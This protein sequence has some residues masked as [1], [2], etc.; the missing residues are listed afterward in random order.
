LLLRE[1]DQRLGLLHRLAGCFRDYR[2]PNSTEYSVK[3]LVA[4]R[5]Y[6]L[7]L[8]YEDLNDHETLRSDRPLR[9]WWASATSPASGA[10]VPVTRAIHWR[11]RAL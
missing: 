7:A 10:G 4:Q 9:C 6:G 5:I 11:V 2:N 3:A 8:G 1:V